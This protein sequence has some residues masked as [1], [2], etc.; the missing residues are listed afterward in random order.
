MRKKVLVVLL[1]LVAAVTALVI[2]GC[3]CSAQQSS[4]ASSSM[5]A[6][7]T[8]ASASS[9]A[10]V[11]VPN[12]VWLEQKDA[13]AQLEKVGL[14]MGDV[15]QEYS[16]TVPS[17][18]VISQKPEALSKADAGSKVA[19]TVSKGKQAPKE[20]TVP[21]LRGKTPTEAEKAIA[22]AGLAVV[23]GDP[24]I[25]DTVQPGLV[26]RQSIGAGTK[27]DEGTQIA[28]NTAISDSNVEVP[29]C[30]GQ[31]YEGAKNALANLGLG[32]DEVTSYSEDVDEGLVMGQSVSSGQSVA[33]GTIITLT[34][35][36]GPKPSGQVN[37]PDVYTYHLD[38]AKATLEAAG[39]ECRYTGD[40][41]GTVV[42]M[43]PEPDTAAEAGSVVT[44]R[45]QSVITSVEVPNIVG[46]TGEKA[47]QVCK[48][49][50]LMLELDA[51]ADD[52]V[53]TGQKPEAGAIVDPE[54]PV[55]GYV[56]DVD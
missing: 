47:K 8:S 2:T 6:S 20:T 1:A 4:S 33:K 21:D 11:E 30:V 37:V 24:V 52:Q 28:I 39:F 38:E 12:V 42:A 16:D 41:D 18:L 26:C 55:Y 51:D 13:Q 53:I 34:V 36:L 23:M 40:E 27:V 5:A 54:T 45:L 44:I 15:T 29:E 22:D 32:V 14:K 31:P 35:S 46:M 9:S 25:D 49:H 17:G 56:N 7:D 19:L 3:S 10:Q 43:N 50:L 48:D